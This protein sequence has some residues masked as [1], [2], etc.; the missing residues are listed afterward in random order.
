MISVKYASI[1]AVA[2]FVSGSFVAS[3]ELRAYAANTV[4][5]TDIKDGEV[6]TADLANNAV[7][8]AKIKDNE[9]KAAEIAPNAVG[10]SEIAADSVGASELQ[11]LNKLMHA[12]CAIPPSDFLFSPGGATIV[13]CGTPGVESDDDVFAVIS[14]Q[15]NSC[16][17][18]GSVLSSANNVAVIIKNECNVLQ[19]LR[20]GDW[21][22]LMVFDN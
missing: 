12:G 21:M 1:I 14:G 19:P 8:A 20:A 15:H 18:V 2:A 17:V 9:V 22:S 11:G 6:K 16:F 10:S 5:S 4:F 3:P 7:T 13:N